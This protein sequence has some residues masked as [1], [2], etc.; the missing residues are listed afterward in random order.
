VSH[1]IQDLYYWTILV[2]LGFTS[3]ILSMTAPPL[4]GPAPYFFIG[5]IYGVA[6]STYLALVQGYRS[7]SKMA[8]GI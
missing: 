7:I 5:G 8:H 2:L 1:S 3:G 6:L 4:K